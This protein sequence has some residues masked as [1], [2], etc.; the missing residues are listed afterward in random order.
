LIASGGFA[1]PKSLVWE[2]WRQVRANKGA[3]G[4]DRQ[5][6]EYEPVRQRAP[7]PY[8]MPTVSASARSLSRPM[9]PAT[10]DDC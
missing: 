10:P 2:A 9:G 8:S 5:D 7:R 6:L 3:P 4:V 1:I